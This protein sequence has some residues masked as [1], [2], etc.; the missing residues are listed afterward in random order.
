[1]KTKINT[2]LLTVIFSVLTNINLIAQNE[3]KIQKKT[4]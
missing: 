1:M 4:N 3:N 2:I